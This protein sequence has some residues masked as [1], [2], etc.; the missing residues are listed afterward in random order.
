MKVLQSINLQKYFFK[1]ILSTKTIFND[2]QILWRQI[3]CNAC[4]CSWNTGKLFQNLN[5][6]KAIYEFD[7]KYKENTFYDS[8]VSLNI[9]IPFL[10]LKPVQFPLQNVFHNLQIFSA[11]LIQSGAWP[12]IGSSLYPSDECHG[13]Y[14]LELPGIS[15]FCF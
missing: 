2:E 6:Y 7:K 8:S 4:T 1:N 12:W 10:I 3:L 5:A 11:S 15:S 13:L 14:I 9:D